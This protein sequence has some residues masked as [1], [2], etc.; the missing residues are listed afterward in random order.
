ME[1][2]V[3]V[4]CFQQTGLRVYG[5]FV[6]LTKAMVMLR[7]SGFDIRFGARCW[8]GFYF[9]FLFILFSFFF[10]L[11]IAYLLQA[12]HTICVYSELAF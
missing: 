4:A 10:L 12:G 7:R 3:D 2:S 1:V 5:G 8:G 9:L 6:F 11:Y